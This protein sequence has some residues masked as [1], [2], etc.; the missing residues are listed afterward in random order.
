MR[1]KRPIKPGE[2]FSPDLHIDRRKKEQPVILRNE[3][4]WFL[5][6]VPQS[7]KLK[8]QMRTVWQE[9]QGL[10]RKYYLKDLRNHQPKTLEQALPKIRRKKTEEN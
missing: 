6:P 10:G 7:A 9:G 8:Q 3:Q 4:P 2:K 1:P 5:E